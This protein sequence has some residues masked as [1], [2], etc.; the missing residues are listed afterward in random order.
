MNSNSRAHRQLPPG[1]LSVCLENDMQCVAE[2]VHDLQERA[3]QLLDAVDSRWLLHFGTALDE[4]LSNAILHGNL[5]I[6]SQQR[7]SPEYEQLLLQRQN[8]FPFQRRK[9]LVTARFENTAAY[10]TI[11]DEGPGFDHRKVPDPTDLANLDKPYGRG[12]MMIRAYMDVVQYNEA[13]N[14]ITMSKRCRPPV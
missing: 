9:V 3:Q 6:T 14:S 4:A 5:E 13:G 8:S 2:V 10:V 1:N 7:F 11:A 12:V